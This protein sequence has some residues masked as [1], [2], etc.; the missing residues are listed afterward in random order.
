VYKSS[1]SCP[2]CASA[3]VAAIGVDPTLFG[4][5]LP[6]YSF[7]CQLGHF[8]TKISGGTGSSGHLIRTLG[9]IQCSDGSTSTAVWGDPNADPFS[10]PAIGTF[11]TGCS[12]IGMRSEPYTIRTF[13]FSACGGGAVG[14]SRD[15]SPA[16]LACPPGMV[17]VGVHGLESVDNLYTLGLFCAG[18]C[19]L[20][21]DSLHAF[22]CGGNLTDL[23]HSSRGP[24]T[25]STCAC[26]LPMQVGAQSSLTCFLCIPVTDP[27]C[28]AL[29]GLEERTAPAACRVEDG[30][31]PATKPEAFALWASMVE[32]GCWQAHS[33]QRARAAAQLHPQDRAAVTPA[34]QAQADPRVLHA[35]WVSSLIPWP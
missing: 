2:S 30:S 12:T 22:V 31:T 7:Q 19:M 9:P 8:V 24:A 14:S 35:P 29:K 34:C 13:N 33:A 32:A 23:D 6:S 15:G 5:D 20:P 26:H 17:I 3:G 11:R 28:H 21:L 4:T 16:S 1:P 27:Q 10:A 25:L 18:R